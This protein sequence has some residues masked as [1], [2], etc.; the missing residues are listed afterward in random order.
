MKAIV[1]YGELPGQVDYREIEEPVCGYR[2]VKIEI[3]ACAICVTDLHIM[4]GAYP[5]KV[6]TPLGHE[7]CGIVVETGKGV[8]KFKTGDRVVACM[9]GGFSRYVVK[10][11]E[12]WVFHLPD[13][14]S[15]KEGALLE[16]LAAAANSV[17][18]KSHILP[19]DHVLIEGPGVI[20]LLTLQAAKLQGAFAMVSGTDSDTE[21]LLMAKKLGADKILNVQREDILAACREF[22]QGRGMDT[23]LEC[24]GSQAALDTGLKVLTYNGQLTQ[25]GI[26]GRRASADLGSMVYQNQRIVGSIAY[27]RETWLRVIALVQKGRVN[28]KSLISHTFPLSEWEKGFAMARNKEGY[29]IVLIP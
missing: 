13:E 5:W 25:V 1:K 11:E 17:F 14:I 10:D 28:V 2:D 3:K 18:N 12:D 8:T 4:E 26:F 21:R 22:T 29:R 7:F 27:D 15:F 16:P 24:S 6:N 9:D 23:V 19:G 20:G